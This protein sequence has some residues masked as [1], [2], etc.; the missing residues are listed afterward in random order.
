VLFYE[1]GFASL[2]FFLTGYAAKVVGFAFIGD[3]VFGRVF[4]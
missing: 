1:F 4:V 3:F 2:E